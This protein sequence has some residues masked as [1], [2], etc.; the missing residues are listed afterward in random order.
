MLQPTRLSF[1]GAALKAH[2]RQAK[3]GTGKPQP[4]QKSTLRPVKEA[5]K[6][7][8]TAKV[9]P[10]KRILSERSITSVQDGGDVKRFKID[11]VQEVPVQLSTDA[12]DINTIADELADMFE[13]HNDTSDALATVPAG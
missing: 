4:V 6:Q 12:A 13:E 7:P 3:V 1:N 5:T 11:T 2:E 8:I 10:K 9:Q